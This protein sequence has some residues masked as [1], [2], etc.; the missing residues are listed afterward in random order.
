M[1]RQR[2]PQGIHLICMV[3]YIS[4]KIECLKAL[5]PNYIIKKLN[6]GNHSVL[7][8][9]FQP[10]DIKSGVKRKALSS[11]PPHRYSP[12]P[13]QSISLLGPQPKTCTYT[14]DRERDCS[15]ISKTRPLP[16]ASASVSLR[17]R[18]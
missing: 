2:P 12:P 8:H 17:G 16:E 3:G 1:F 13:C 5:G 14:Q 15:S 18:K 7:K 9:Y 6:G 11:L 10:L 4:A